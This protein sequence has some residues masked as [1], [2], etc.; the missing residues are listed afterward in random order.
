MVEQIFIISDWYQLS[1]ARSSTNTKLRVAVSK[2]NDMPILDATCIRVIHDDY[3]VVFAATVRA[4]G[5]ILE[6]QPTGGIFYLTPD[7][8]LSELYKWGFYVE[9]SVRESLSS[10]QL[11]YLETIKRLGFDKL[12]VLPVIKNTSCTNHLVAFNV[13]QNPNWLAQTYKA[14]YNEFCN[15]LENGT[16]VDLTNISESK[17]FD[18]TWL[19][20]VANIDDI[21][22]DNAEVISGDADMNSPLSVLQ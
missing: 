1:K 22:Q 2:I 8:I 10:D 6:E 16:A 14:Y 11:S 3:G 7:Q 13:E 12:R 19:D 5:E 9:F 17:Q 15:A 21:L 4:K 18:W 20:Y